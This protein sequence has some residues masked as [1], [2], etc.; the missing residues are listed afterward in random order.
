V[1]WI[2]TGSTVTQEEITMNTQ[3]P[4][5]AHVQ[6]LID[7]HFDIW[8]D[9]EPKNWQAKFPQVYTADFYVADYA[10]VATGYDDVGKLILKVQQEH[11]GFRFRPEPVSW[12]H[13]VGRVTWGYGPST[14]PDLV[15]GED[16]FTIKDGKLASARVFLD[17]K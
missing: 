15:R 4:D 17:K 9:P 6:H 13:G 11:A 10:G 12:N 7:L 5:I 16:I 14:N 2:Y 3:E 1:W 8:N